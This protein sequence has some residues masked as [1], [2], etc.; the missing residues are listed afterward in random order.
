[1]Y[2]VYVKIVF[3]WWSS[4]S[5]N[6]AESWYGAWDRP[7]GLENINMRDKYSSDH[8]PYQFLSIRCIKNNN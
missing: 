2:R 5:T 8:F 6:F 1:M 4:D 7:F 3:Y